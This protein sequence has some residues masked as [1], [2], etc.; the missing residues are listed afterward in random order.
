MAIATAIAFN[1]TDKPS[2]VLNAGSV[3]LADDA[4]FIIPYKAP[5][6]A[7]IKPNFAIVSLETLSFI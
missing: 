5:T 4:S 3:S 7:D 1:N 2:I 6:T